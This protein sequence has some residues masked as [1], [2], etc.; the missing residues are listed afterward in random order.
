MFLG[1]DAMDRGL[2]CVHTWD[3]WWSFSFFF[4]FISHVAVVFLVYVS[5]RD[6]LVLF[7]VLFKVVNC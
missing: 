6:E 4:T 2:L 5:I 3:P 1:W 7:I